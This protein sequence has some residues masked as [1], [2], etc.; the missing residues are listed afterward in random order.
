MNL[1]IQQIHLPEMNLAYT[2]AANY[3][4]ATLK[5]QKYL[6]LNDIDISTVDI[7]HAEII[8]LNSKIIF[9]YTPAIREITDY[10]RTEIQILH[11]ESGLYLT[12]KV[13]KQQYQEMLFENQELQK[14][15]N[16]EIEDY[17]KLH[18]VYQHMPAFPYLAK[19]TD[20]KEQLF[21]P[22]KK[23]KAD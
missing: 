2:L 1:F 22:I 21:F 10:D 4:E 13:E 17:C 23:N 5:L 20:G 19:T 6:I 3:K 8:T 9:L 18:D 12:M 7:Y 11:V 14:H 16:R 15:F